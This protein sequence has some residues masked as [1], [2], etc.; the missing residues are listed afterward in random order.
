MGRSDPSFNKIK[1]IMEENPES[2]TSAEGVLML[3]NLNGLRTDIHSIRVLA[4]F[5]VMC[6]VVEKMRKDYAWCPM[7]SGSMLMRCWQK[8]K[9]FRQ[10]DTKVIM[11]GIFS[12]KN[13]CFAITED[14]IMR[15]WNSVVHDIGLEFTLKYAKNIFD[16]MI[17]CCKRTYPEEDTD[18]WPDTRNPAKISSRRA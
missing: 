7:S 6:E 12:E 5:C 18:K 13:L 15:F 8:S 10:I 3:M 14:F 4:K 11:T 17:Q 1:R 2:S 16:D 9:K